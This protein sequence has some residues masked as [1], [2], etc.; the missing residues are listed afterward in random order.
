[1][2]GSAIQIDTYT[3]QPPF[4]QNAASNNRPKRPAQSIIP[5]RFYHTFIRPGRCRVINIRAGYFM[6][7]PAH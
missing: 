7:H 3:F 4:K 6:F 1:M 5:F 2:N